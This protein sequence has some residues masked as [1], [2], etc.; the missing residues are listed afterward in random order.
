MNNK[1]GMMKKIVLPAIPILAPFLSLAQRDNGMP[2]AEDVFNT[3][4]SIAVV[5]LL[6]A[7]ILVIMKRVMDNRLK[8]KI[9][10]KGIPDFVT[11]PLFQSTAPDQRSVTIKWALLL[12]GLGAAFT[13]IHYTLPLGIHSL[14]ILAFCLSASFLCYYL[15]LKKESR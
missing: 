11:L 9:I 14:A 13:I 5:A 7:F 12:A 1:N 4:A 6:M 10:E 8:N 3:I 2:N 15:F